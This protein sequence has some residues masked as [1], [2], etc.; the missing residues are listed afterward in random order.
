MI[1]AM[2]ITLVA[3]LLPADSTP[4]RDDPLTHRDK[5]DREKVLRRFG[6]T[7]KTERA[8]TDGLAWLAAHQRPDGIWDRRGFHR[9]CPKNDQC[10]QAA[11]THAGRNADAGLSALAALAFLGAGYT[12]EQGAYAENLSRVFSYLLAQQDAAGSF[13][14]DSGFQMYNDA[15]ATIAIAEAFAMTKDPVLDEPLRRAIAHLVRSQQ[16][17]G[18]WDYTSDTTTNRNDTS[19]TSWVVMAFKSARAAGVSVPLATRLRLIE[20]FDRS[21]ESSG[22]VWYADKSESRPNRPGYRRRY[23]PAMIATSLFARSAFGF[24]LDDTI[25]KR[26]AAQL[27]NDAPSLDKLRARDSTGLHSAYYWYYGTLGLF[28]V[29][30]GPWRQ[31]NTALRGSVLEYQERPVAKGGRR[32]HSFGSWPAFGRGW[33]KWGRTG[34]RVYSTAIN[35]LTLEVYYR[36]VP[37]YLSP[38]GLIGPADLRRHMAALTPAEHGDVL[39]LARRM[40]P[41]TAEPALLDLLSSLNE[42][43]RLE[44]AIALGEL[45]SP[46]ARRVLTK[47]RNSARPGVRKRMVAALDRITPPTLGVRYGPVT[48]VS[49]KARMVLFD[50]GGRALY[51]GQVVGITRDGRTVATARVNR[52]F[53]ANEAAAARIAEADADVKIGDAVVSL[54]EEP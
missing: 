30:G 33:G 11:L 53:S 48:E 4:P 7:R 10:S 29:G 42:E 40:Q 20:H 46:M 51:Y 16:P 8:V 47:A 18:G 52:R 41:D 6:G 28:N 3:L 17:G 37:A 5:Q 32:G 22:R 24:R 49:P 45:G 15:M 44:A 34:G 25:S 23:G 21:A 39:S 31:W 9:M 38:R 36:Y 14:A 54:R 50:T 13:S 12:H 43:V 1:P 26:Q 27:L 2:T 35:T 19:I